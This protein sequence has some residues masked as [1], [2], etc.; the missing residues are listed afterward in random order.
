ML[1]EH[2]IKFL[3]EQM[4]SKNIED[5]LWVAAFLKEIGMLGRRLYNLTNDEGLK[6]NLFTLKN[7]IESIRL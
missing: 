7:V 6:H 3:R 2:D 4:R 5:R 1:T